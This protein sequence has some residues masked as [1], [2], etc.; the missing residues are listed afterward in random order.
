MHRHA[1]ICKCVK[2]SQHLARS[3]WCCP[4]SVYRGLA[5]WPWEPVRGSLS[6]EDWLS[7]SQKPVLLPASVFQERWTVDY[8]LM[9]RSVVCQS[10]VHAWPLFC[11]Q[12]HF[13]VCRNHVVAWARASVE[14]E[15][16]GLHWW[17]RVVLPCA[18]AGRAGSQWRL[19]LSH[20][21]ICCKLVALLP[22]PALCK[23]GGF[24]FI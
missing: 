23:E 22:P 5:F 20:L 3:L 10:L 19:I 7:L 1:C 13:S 24:M 16:N 4:M 11:W 9:E 12:I 17:Q 2:R 21:V 6:G 18:E 8:I 14:M 15:K